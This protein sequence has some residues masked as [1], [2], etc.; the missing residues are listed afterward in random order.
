MG[1]NWTFKELMEAAFS[2]EK[3][4]PTLPDEATITH[5]SYYE[6]QNVFVNSSLAK[7]Y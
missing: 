1:F 7:N 2:S 6:Q 4:V 5:N 3:F